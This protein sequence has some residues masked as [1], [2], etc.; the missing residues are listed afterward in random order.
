M[1]M[2][3]LSREVL[4]ARRR[5]HPFD[6]FAIS[7]ISSFFIVAA[8]C[9]TPAP[10]S[11]GISALSAPCVNGADLTPP[12]LPGQDSR[13]AF[14][15]IAADS[16]V[17][18]AAGRYELVSPAPVLTYPTV[19][20]TMPANVQLIGAGS[21]ATILAF[22][23]DLGANAWYGIRLAPGAWIHDLALVDET[24]ATSPN[25]QRHMIRMDGSGSTVGVTL[26]HIACTHF[27]GGDCVQLVGYAPVAPTFVDRR[28]WNVTVHDIDCTSHRSCIAVHSGVN[29]FEFY[30]V[31]GRAWDQVFDFEGGGDIFDGNIHD[32]VIQ[33]ATG[34]QSS[35]GADINNLTRLHFHHNTMALGYQV[36]GCATCEFDHNVVTQ[37]VPSNS[38]VVYVL[39]GDNVWF[40]DEAWTRPAAVNNAPVFAAIKH[41]SAPIQN[42]RITDSTLTQHM[43]WTGVNLVGVD[44]FTL[45]HS[46]VSID[47]QG[48]ARI[49]LN[50][51]N[52]K[53]GQTVVTQSANINVSFSRFVSAV[54]FYA[55]ITVGAGVGA[56]SVT[57]NIVTNATRGMVCGAGSGPF[58]Y[59]SNTMP[60][61]QCAMGP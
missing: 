32:N 15:A 21:G 30:N 56:V 36:F 42:M 8:A 46:S 24:T 16:C 2:I 37:S 7:A 60:A 18:L 10:A 4:P 5:V 29:S 14:A 31:V 51:E 41:G 34:Q 53:S 58:T 55:A 59:E 48:P 22:T 45:D 50:V 23:G 28:I 13:A 11:V 33:A 39:A 47:G 57:D 26:D 61:P 35:I 27:A 54:A 49:G 43:S 52:L 19:V 12:I 1:V 40:H 3:D 6:L 20:W 44:G 25:E 38:A 9:I 17:Q